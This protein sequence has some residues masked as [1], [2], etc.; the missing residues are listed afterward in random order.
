MQPKVG[1]PACV[2]LREKQLGLGPRLWF[3][4]SLVPRRHWEPQEV[5]KGVREGE[6]GG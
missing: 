6:Q 3:P 5:E 1:T 2:P 4:N